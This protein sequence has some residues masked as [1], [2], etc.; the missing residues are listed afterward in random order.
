MLFQ[1][2]LGFAMALFASLLHAK[3]ARRVIEFTQEFRPKTSESSAELW[4]PTP[5][6][7]LSYQTLL[8]REFSG[9]ASIVK[10]VSDDSGPA[11]YVYARWVNVASPHL[12]VIN[13]I[14]VADRQGVDPGPAQ[15]RRFLDSTSHVQTDG[16]VKETATKIVGKISDSDRKARAIYDWI[17]KNASR[18]PDV[19]GCGLGDVKSMLVSGNLSGKC[20]D[21]NS[22]FVGL[23]RASGVP[24]R[25]VFGQRVAASRFFKSIG[26]DGDNSKAQHCRAEYYSDSLMGW[27]PV[28]PADILKVIL[29]E[30][31][32]LKDK[33]LVDL[34]DKFFGFWEGSWVAFNMARDFELTG[35]GK[36]AVNFFMYPLL[37]TAKLNPDGIEP[38]E[39]GYSYMTRTL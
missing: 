6:S 18:N 1:I 13:V 16:I 27:V 36:R 5:M 12:K 17:I 33:N 2:T 10:V 28:D 19:R 3:D 38:R 23:A 9:N 20:A 22:L 21:L 35:Y 34:G 7:G 11:P 4:I 37:K 32:T 25:E 8:S 24:A 30:K 31:L 39:A 26:K 29:E 14:E 15:G